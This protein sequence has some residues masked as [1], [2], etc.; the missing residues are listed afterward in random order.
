MSKTITEALE[1]ALECL[2]ETIPNK[3]EDLPGAM[4]NHAFNVNASKQI[5][6][7]SHKDQLV[8][9]NTIANCTAVDIESTIDAM[10]TDIMEK[11][12]FM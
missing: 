2:S 4:D 3:M 5:M 10:V 9:L 7:A 6:R 8:M 1:H 12:G 11:E